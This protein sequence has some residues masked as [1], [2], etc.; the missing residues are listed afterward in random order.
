[1][2]I[3]LSGE[4]HG[5]DVSLWIDDPNQIDRPVFEIPLSPFTSAAH[6]IG[7]L[8][9]ATSI[10]QWLSGWGAV[11]E[12]IRLCAGLGGQLEARAE[13]RIVNDGDIQP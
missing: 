13:L 12:V 9:V 4:P 11:P 1:M 8:P 5:A 7:P 6:T 3:T 10:V 2:T